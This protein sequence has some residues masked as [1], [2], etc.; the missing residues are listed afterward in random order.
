MADKQTVRGVAVR[1]F[2]DAG[3]TESFVAGEGYD[4]EPGAF[5]NYRAGGL[6]KPEPKAKSRGSAGTQ[7]NA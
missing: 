5:K 2:T 6:M 4:L 7:P 3:T 1:D